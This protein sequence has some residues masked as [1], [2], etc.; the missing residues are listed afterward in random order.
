[1]TNRAEPTHGFKKNHMSDSIANVDI[2]IEIHKARNRGKRYG[3]DDFIYKNSVCARN[4]MGGNFL[5]EI[6]KYS[7]TYFEKNSNDAYLVVKYFPIATTRAIEN[8]DKSISYEL[9]A[10]SNNVVI[11]AEVQ[12]AYKSTIYELYHL[13]SA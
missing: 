12:I 10:R 5:V 9:D 7:W 13:E 4:S 6:A 3:Q 8:P 2:L 11:Y 1:M